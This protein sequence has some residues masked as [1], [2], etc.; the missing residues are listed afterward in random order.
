MKDFLSYCFLHPPC[1][2]T[3]DFEV[4]SYIIEGMQECS[5]INI[6]FANGKIKL[7]LCLKGFVLFTTLNTVNVSTTWVK[8]SE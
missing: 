5:I 7:W 6:Y 1:T 3:C 4:H 2:Q 8:K